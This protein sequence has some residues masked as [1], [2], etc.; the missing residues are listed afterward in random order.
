MYCTFPQVLLAVYT[1]LPQIPCP[2]S[3]GN[4]APLCMLPTCPHPTA[5]DPISSVTRKYCSPLLLFGQFLLPGLSLHLLH[6]NGVRFATAHVQLMVP[7]AQRQDALVD[8]KTRCIEDKIWCFLV[9]W[10]DD[11]FLVIERNVPDLTPGETDLRCE[12]ETKQEQ[13]MLKQSVFTILTGLL[14]SHL[15]DIFTHRQRLH[16]F[17]PL[18]NRKTA[19]VLAFP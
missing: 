1:P 9:N 17:I 6:L 5:P 7:H 18:Y 14:W 4:T 15:P 13:A 2:L 19:P 16:Y 10:F 8:A 3:Q 11:K 12:S